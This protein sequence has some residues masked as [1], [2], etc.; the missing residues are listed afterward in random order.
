MA[1]PNCLWACRTRLHRLV[2]WID[3]IETEFPMSF[4]QLSENE[5]L[6][7]TQV[8]KSLCNELDAYVDNDNCMP[9][10]NVVVTQMGTRR[11]DD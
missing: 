7:V 3:G 5:K 2:R 8:L 10:A 4:T 6:L 9:S 1:K 11:E